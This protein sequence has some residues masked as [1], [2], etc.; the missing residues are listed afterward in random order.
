MKSQLSFNFKTLIKMLYKGI[1]INSLKSYNGKFL[2]RGS[3]INKKEIEKIKK[4]KKIGK[5]STTVVFSKAFL[6]FSEDENQ[7]RNFCGQSDD[8]K[9]GILFILENNN[10]HPHESNANIQNFS[11]FPKEKE[12]LFFPG[13]S[14]IIKNI[15]DINDNN[16]EITLNYIG[17]FKEKYNF[18]YNDKEKIN[19][20]INN[21]KL[22]KNIAGKKLEF[23]KGG[24]Y[25]KLEKIDSWGIDSIFK[26]KDLEKDE[27]VLIRV[28]ELEDDL[29]EIGNQLKSFSETVNYSFKYRDHFKTEKYSYIIFDYCDDNLDNYLEKKKL[30][31]K[32]IKKIFKQ[33]NLVFKE[34][35]NAKFLHK[36]IRPENILINYLNEEK[37]NFD[38]FL[39]NLGKAI[40]GKRIT[41]GPEDL[42]YCI[43]EI[44]M[45]R[46]NIQ[47]NK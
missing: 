10:N 20:L 28:L 40:T 7:A 32:L 46:F 24:K 17:K 22:T 43:P 35:F 27:I 2:Y 3:V 6:S 31:P 25:L 33:L 26:G 47:F 30:S 16:V 34:I 19:N 38:C 36:D 18:I 4:Y 11:V 1:E 9:I 15:R 29:I 41:V 14:F 44:L 45:E 13:A 5:L 8:T 23:L 42:Y 37:T 21:N 12:I 39:T